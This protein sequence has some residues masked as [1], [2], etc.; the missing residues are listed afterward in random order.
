MP[1]RGTAAGTTSTTG[2]SATTWGWGPA[3]TASSA[4]LTACCA[5]C[6]RASRACT[7]KK[8][9]PATPVS[10]EEVARRDLP[11]EYM[12]NA[13]RLRDGFAVREMLER[14]GLPASAFRGG[15][16]AGVARGWLTEEGG[17]VRPT[18][19][20]FDFLSDLQTLF[21]PD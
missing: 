13:L 20:G 4:S 18:G 3:R 14:T 21:L 2:S 9:V 11:F 8:R 6:A 17:W 12:L 16:D 1:G 7:W 10:S 15:I 19:Q 5:R